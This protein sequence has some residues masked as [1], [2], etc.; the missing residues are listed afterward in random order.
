MNG[1]DAWKEVLTIEFR[2]GNKMW[3]VSNLVL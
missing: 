1:E 2:I 3:H